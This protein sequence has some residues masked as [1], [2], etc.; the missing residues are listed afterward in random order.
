MMVVEGAC[1]CNEAFQLKKM[2]VARYLSLWN[3]VDSSASTALLIGASAH[4]LHGGVKMVGAVGVALK[5][6][7]FIDY[8]RCFQ[9]TGSLVRMVVVIVTDIQPFLLLLL[10]A[11]L[12]NVS[13][14]MV[15]QPTSHLF[16]FDGTLNPLMTG[17]LAMLGSFEVTDYQGPSKIM[18]F[19]FLFIVVIVLLNLLIAIMGDSY[20]KVKENETVHALHERAKMIVEMEVQH[21]S[22]HTFYE[23]MH[24]VEAADEDSQQT[25][26]WEG[27][28]GRVK[29][30][31]DSTNA[32]VDDV[33]QE[34]VEMAS[35]VEA[36]KDEL[37]FKMDAM[38]GR[39]DGLAGTVDEVKDLLQLLLAKLP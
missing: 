29:Q 5:W 17:F 36:T 4:F 12:A 26:E 24:V 14:L 3:L 21:P 8:L 6:F 27:I 13:F 2:G 18:L 30:L 31:I 32:R 33:Q 19:V 10:L 22:W 38:T 15:N 39:M 9:Q 11:V 7:G 1:L 37:A 35:Q 28:T 34:I 23:F 25:P 16:R 20:E